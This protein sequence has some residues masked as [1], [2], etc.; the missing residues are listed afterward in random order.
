[1]C[2]TDFERDITI[3]MTLEHGV[4]RLATT[5]IES[6]LANSSQI[7]QDSS[8]NNLNYRWASMAKHLFWVAGLPLIL[9]GCLPL[10]FTIASSAITGLSYLTTGKSGTDHVISA[11]R[12]EDCSLTNPFFG[13]DVCQDML[14]GDDTYVAVASYP[15]DR[16]YGWR[17]AQARAVTPTTMVA[18]GQQAAEHKAGPLG[19]QEK[20]AAMSNLVAP[21]PE[22]TIAGLSLGSKHVGQRPQ[23]QVVVQTANAATS[24]TWAST[25]PAPKV[26]TRAIELTPLPAPG[27][28]DAPVPPRSGRASGMD[29]KVPLAN[30]RPSDHGAPHTAPKSVEAPS[31]QHAPP[32]LPR[33]EHGS[34]GESGSYIVVG[35][36]RDLER[37][38]RLAAALADHT[39]KILAA[40]VKGERWNRVAIGPFTSADISVAKASL[41][42]VSGRQP[43]VVRLESPI[44]LASN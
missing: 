29:V 36:F 4:S 17:T 9:G 24:T 1:L 7:A 30:A 15:G 32:S 14:A 35:S 27:G 39:P 42:K 38:D 18:D 3:G 26:P 2:G 43:W 44:I 12:K 8:H 28:F 34:L 6:V 37:A 5:P 41:G 16:D 23:R 40:T 25:E 11:A 21:P 19:H 33:V 31:A 13:Q 20:L 10:P 22:I